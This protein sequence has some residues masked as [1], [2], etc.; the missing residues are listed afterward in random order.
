M[1]K[2][3][4]CLDELTKLSTQTVSKV[5]KTHMIKTKKIKMPVTQKPVGSGSIANP[6]I[7]VGHAGSVGRMVPPPPVRA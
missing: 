4:A 2:W 6:A 1:T 3:A 5:T 7:E